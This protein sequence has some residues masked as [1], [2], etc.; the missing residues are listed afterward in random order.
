MKGNFVIGCVFSG[1]LAGIP[2]LAAESA[3]PPAPCATA[4]EGPDYVPGVD[5]EGQPVVR[6]DLGADHAAIPDQVFVPLPDSGP[7]QRLGRAG[8]GAAR[9]GPYAAIDGR[10]LEPLL[11]P[12]PC[13]AGPEPAVQP[14]PRPR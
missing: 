13:A 9:N 11:N 1:L 4:L 6:A 12:G 8:R 7:N 2:A 10:R 3:A 14:S 5:A